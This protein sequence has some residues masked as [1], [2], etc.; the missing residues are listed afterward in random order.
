MAFLYNIKWSMEANIRTNTFMQRPTAINCKVGFLR[1][2]LAVSLS[3]PVLIIVLSML[4][5]AVLNHRVRS[6]RVSGVNSPLET[7][8]V[9]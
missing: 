7:L 5:S 9:Q 4:Q 2:S 1:M 8:T 6:V 3:E